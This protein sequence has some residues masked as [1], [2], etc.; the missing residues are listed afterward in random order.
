LGAKIGCKGNATIR[1]ICPACRFYRE[2]SLLSK[3]IWKRENSRLT[4]T[5]KKCLSGKVICA[6]FCPAYRSSPVFLLQMEAHPEQVICPETCGKS[7]PCGHTCQVIE[8]FDHCLK[9]YCQQIPKMKTNRNREY[10]HLV[11]SLFAFTTVGARRT[12]GC[13]G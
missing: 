4:F 11:G 6:F 8:S 12:W 9:S 13:R 5:G 1:G 7:L 10:S 2:N 3:Q